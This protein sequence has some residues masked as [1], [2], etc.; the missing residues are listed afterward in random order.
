M[1]R[2]VT[3][4][5]AWLILTGVVSVPL[6]AIDEAQAPQER[7]PAFTVG[8]GYDYYQMEWKAESKW[9]TEK[10]TTRQNRIYLHGTY[11][12]NPRWEVGGRLGAG[13]MRVPDREEDRWIADL[14]SNRSLESGFEAFGSFLTR[15]AVRGDPL[16]TDGAALEVF[17]QA[18]ASRPHKDEFDVY[19]NSFWDYPIHARVRTEVREQWG[20][21]TGFLL[22]GGDRRFSM[23][24]GFLLEYAGAVRQIDIS[25]HDYNE[26]ESK[27]DYIKNSQN[28]WIFYVL[29]VALWRGVALDTFVELGP[30]FLISAQLTST[31]LR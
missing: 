31:L 23:G 6:E 13:D 2:G 21:R 27:T 12:V 29:R 30:N 26:S 17:L 8:V 20:T 10:F 5:G 11:L 1:R 3:I 15:A 16:Y 19:F 28:L 25:S 24:G 4:T 9:R 18:W 22:R 14:G 7:G